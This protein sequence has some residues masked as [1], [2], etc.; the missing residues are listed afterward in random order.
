MSTIRDE[1]T[2]EIT[3]PVFN[4]KIAPLI[5]SGKLRKSETEW[6][7]TYFW[8]SDTGLNVACVAQRGELWRAWLSEYWAIKFGE[9]KS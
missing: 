6:E 8:D 4:Q 1:F 7:T 2:V 3:R 5:A 9:V